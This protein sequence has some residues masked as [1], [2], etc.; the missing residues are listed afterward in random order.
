VPIIITTLQKFPFVT[1][2][3]GDLPKRRYAVI[4]DEAHSSQGG[5]SATELKGVLAA[6][7]IKEEVQAKAKAEGLRDWRSAHKMSARGRGNCA[8]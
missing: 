1:E 5:E 6:A 3:I 7:A 8:C 4:I 2:K